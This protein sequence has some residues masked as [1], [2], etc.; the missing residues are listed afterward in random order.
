LTGHRLQAQNPALPG[1]S[2]DAL[3]SGDHREQLH[4]A[5]AV[6]AFKRVDV[7]IAGLYPARAAAKLVVTDA[8]EYE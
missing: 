4:A 2:L 5:V 6:R 1:V 7:A 8:L 3:A